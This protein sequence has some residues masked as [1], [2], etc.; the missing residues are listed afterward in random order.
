MSAANWREATMVIDRKGGP[1]SVSLFE[2]FVRE[3]KIKLM[4]VSVSQ[5]ELARGAWRMFGRGIHP[6]GSN[7][8]DGFAYALAKET[9]KP[10]LFK[11]NHFRAP[12]SSRR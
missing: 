9:R 2:D 7:N 10:I 1:V 4:P 3:A 11:G 5:A 8:D 12:T 6:T